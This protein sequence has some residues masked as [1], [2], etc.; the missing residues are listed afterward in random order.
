MNVQVVRRKVV[1]YHYK[2][3]YCDIGEVKG[4]KCRVRF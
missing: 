3:I 2:G 4:I 1:E